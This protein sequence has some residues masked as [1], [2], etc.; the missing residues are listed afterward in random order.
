MKTIHGEIK[1]PFFM[2]I[3]TKG[4]IKNIS[5]FEMKEIGAEIILANTYH[6]FLQPGYKIIKKIGDL[7][8]FINWRG[9]ILTDSGGFQVFSLG[10]GKRNNEKKAGWRKNLVRVSDRG[11]EF[12]SYIDGSKHFLTPELAIEIQRAFGSDITMVLDQCIG[13]PCSKSEAEE[14]VE[15]TLKWAERSKKYEVGSMNYELGSGKPLVFGIVQGSIYKN[16]RIK[17][18]K[19]LVEMNFDGY[20]IGGL[21]VGEPREK[22]L[23]ALDYTVPLLPEDRPRYLM[24]V[25]RPEEIVEAVKRGIDMFDCV[26][27]TREGRHG[28]IY[29]WK[30]NSLKGNKFY[31]VINITNG[32]FRRDFKVLDPECDCPACRGGYTRAYLHHL[33]KIGEGLGLRLASLHNLRF[34]LKLM[35]IIREQIKNNKI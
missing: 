2:P 20:A 4:A 23:K 30:N 24:G 12:K 9:P 3:A 25:G 26:I 11:V 17:C 13:W 29:I 5:S 15:R 33:F 34:Y 27:P 19:R 31:K 35:E 14:A 32:S 18:V 1:M 16:L 8:R 21:A 6:L 28:R 22:M 7:H 10:A